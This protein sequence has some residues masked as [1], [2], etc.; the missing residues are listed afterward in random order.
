MTAA[1]SERPHW[2]AIRPSFDPLVARVESSRLS[3]G[4]DELLRESHWR[5]GEDARLRED[6]R[7]RPT[8]WGRWIA[9]STYL[10]NDL[11][12]AKLH[13]ESRGRLTVEAELTTLDGLVKRRCVLCPADPRVV[14]E[15]DT[16]RLSA[17]ELT[18]Q[19]LVEPEVGDLERYVTHLPVHSLKA[20]AA[21][22]PAGEWGT[23]AQDEVIETM[24]WVR[25]EAGRKLNPRMF[26]A[27]IEGRSMD[28]GRSG[29][30]DG[31]YAVFELWPAG[32]KQNLNVLVRGAFSDPETGSYA[33]K[34]YLTDERDADGWHRRITLVSLNPDKDRYPDIELAPEGDD[35]VT[36][37]AKVLQALSSDQFARRPRPLRRPG[38]RDLTSTEAVAE[39]AEDLAAHIERFF[40]HL[41]AEN[42]G[43]PEDA[44]AAWGAE[45]VCLDAEAGGLHI[46]LGPLFGLWSFVKQLRVRGDEWA[47]TVLA[48]N[49]RMRPTRV[50]VLPGTGPWRWEAVGFEDDADLDFSALA[51]G[52][53]K[54]DCATVFRVDADGVGRRIGSGTLTVGRQYRLLI[55]D[56]V[57]AT[58]PQRPSAHPAGAGWSLWEID[59]ADSVDPAV[60]AVL[61]ELGLEIGE[62][63]ALLDWVLV[64]PIAWRHNPRGLCY[65]CFLREPSPVVALEG[66]G[67]ETAGG[68]SLFLHGPRGHEVLPLPPG[69][70]HHVRLDGLVPGRYSIMVLY[71]R[72]AIA[73]ERLVFEVVS[74]APGTPAAAWTV[75]ARGET[76]S[77]GNGPVSVCAA[78]D[79]AQLDDTPPPEGD[80]ALTVTVPPGWPVRVLWRELAEDLLATV[81]AD[82]DGK[83]DGAELL[84]RSRERR[85]RS[86]MGDLI[87]D[88][89]ELGA[90]IVC[91][92]RRP[93]PEGVR[94]RVLE[95]VES[96]GETVQRLAGTYS[97][98]LRIW[99]E[100]L[101]SALG[102]DLDPT[103]IQARTDPAEHVVA[104][105]LLHTE[106]SA[107]LIERHPVR[108]LL[109]VESLAETPSD[110]LLAWIDEVCAD[111]R[112]RDVV[113]S[114]GLRWAGH[115]RGSRLALQVWDLEVVVHDAADF[116]PFLHA[117]AEGV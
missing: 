117:V 74:E 1:L 38:R 11:L 111:E 49:L 8:P 52:P 109:L 98:L 5:L 68:A 95:L 30:V 44:R 50:A 66:P 56:T 101:C 75:I 64:P 13:G 23:S 57:L 81:N 58:L 31:G 91:H 96:R 112:L 34:R 62:Q 92:E 106:R 46:E 73:A 37:V 21:S 86:P 18:D 85:H 24:G 77:S 110:G 40:E 35:E 2:A 28:D 108:V 60:L 39:I 10:A 71:D 78:Q 12:F 43:E 63:E 72:T 102:Y 48:S 32:T 19:P 51:P 25:V 88:F 94:G 79:L 100:P 9:A 93:T 116:Q 41:P 7:F 84:S 20:A 45:L 55:P 65:P 54:P 17:R 70:R 104:H 26:V 105:R 3:V 29:L 69:Q 42:A 67:V 114:D 80:P 47:T 36:V 89:A 59:L 22:L 14:L 16:L 115:R 27:R 82:S 99:F 53:L 83:V 33:V 4:E 107:S 90:A 97:D 6:V 61:R 87:F 76:V 15:G 113:V 103:P